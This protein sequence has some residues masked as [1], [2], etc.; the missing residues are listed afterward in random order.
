MKWWNNSIISKRSV[1]KPGPDYVEGR[2]PFSRTS[3]SEET[4]KKISNSNKGKL[5]WN[6][7]VLTG[8]EPD[9]VRLKKHI[10]AK[11]RDNTVYKNRIP[12]NKG[13]SA[14]Y[15]TRIASYATKQHGTSREGNY[16]RGDKHPGFNPERDAYLRYK[17]EVMILTEASYVKHI[18]IINPLRLP[19]TLAG[20]NGGYQLDHKTPIIHGFRN[21]IPA[22]IIADV[23]NLQ[24]LP[25]KENVIKSDIIIDNEAEFK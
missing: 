21:S 15:D 24:M 19:R 16:V 5:A 11:N 2:L 17:Y 4:R 14:E 13:L 1:S 10:S 20:I 18:D 22:H 23:S 7:G 25:W 3:P 12:W 8:P 9:N 6:K